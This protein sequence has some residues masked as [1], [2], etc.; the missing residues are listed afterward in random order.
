MNKKNFFQNKSILIFGGTG[1][2]GSEIVSQMLNLNPK[3]IRVF[4]NSENELWETKQKFIKFSEKLRFLL[5]DIRNFERVR[6]AMEGIDYVFNAAAI[7]HVPISEYNPIE[8][9]SVNVNGLN[10][11]IE[12]AL[13]YQVK[14]IIQISTDKS[15]LPTTVMGATKMLGERL[16]I[17]RNWAKGEHSLIISAVRFGNVLGSR[18][19]LIPLIKRQIENGNEVTL[20]GQEMNRFFMSIFQAVSLVIHAMIE[21]KGG[22]IFV[23][24]MSTIHIKDL[25]EVI[26]EDYSPKIGKDP[27]KIIIK[28]IGPRLGEKFDEELISPI[29]YVSCFETDD[30]YIIYPLM[31]F[32]NNDQFIENHSGNRVSND[33]EFVYSTQNQKSLNKE[34]IRNLVNNLKLI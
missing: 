20:T 8:A 16:C 7:K 3:V 12:A 18:G 29:E 19:S 31:D 11:I 24:K 4:S 17:S 22:E 34:Q 9:I 1:T 2:I 25:I 33:I 13:L 10:N 28:D 32:G 15:I 14:K 21:A 6:R 30:M 26:I 5:G 23:L 27:S